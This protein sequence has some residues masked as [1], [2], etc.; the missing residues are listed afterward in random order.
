MSIDGQ[1]LSFG[2]TDAVCTYDAGNSNACLFEN[3]RYDIGQMCSHRIVAVKNYVVI[4]CF[5]NFADGSA[6]KVQIYTKDDGILIG[7][8]STP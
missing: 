7:S 5:K 2:S 6:K 1:Q 3:K 8:A 4:S